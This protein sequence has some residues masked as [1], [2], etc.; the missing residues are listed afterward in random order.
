MA[1]GPEMSRIQSVSQLRGL[2]LGHPS[3]QGIAT[4]SAAEH[5]KQ[6]RLSWTG[7]GRERRNVSI[8]WR[9]TAVRTLQPSPVACRSEFARPIGPDRSVVAGLAATPYLKPPRSSPPHPLGTPTPDT[10]GTFR[11]RLMKL[12]LHCTCSLQYAVKVRNPSFA[13]GTE[14]LAAGSSRAAGIRRQFS[15]LRRQ[16]PEGLRRR[17][18]VSVT[19]CCRWR[20]DFGCLPR[21]RLVTLAAQHLLH[22]DRPIAGQPL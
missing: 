3:S 12:S 2:M 18:H 4:E 21:T 19:D 5:R 16:A 8:H 13:M 1:L 20:H 17:S 14:L 10:M 6:G 7:A 9:C 15:P 22:V 11:A